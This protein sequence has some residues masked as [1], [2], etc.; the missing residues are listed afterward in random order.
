MSLS[1]TMLVLLS[2][3]SRVTSFTAFPHNSINSNA[4]AI[5]SAKTRSSPRSSYGKCARFY[6]ALNGHSESQNIVLDDNTVHTNINDSSNTNTS[7]NIKPIHVPWLIVGGGI[8]GVH[9]AA[10]LLGS[11]GKGA[12]INPDDLCIIDGNQHLL[13]MWKSRT[14][15]TGM[16]YLRSSAGYHLDIEENSLRRMRHLTVGEQNGEQEVSNTSSVEVKTRKGRKRRKMNKHK[17]NKTKMGTKAS[18]EQIFSNDYERPRLDIFNQHCD[19]VIE[20]YELDRLHRQG[21]V[22]AID[23]CGS[24]DH[25]RLEVTMASSDNGT[26]TGTGTSSEENANKVVYTAEHIVLALGNDDPSYA[27]WVNKEDIESGLVRHLLDD[28]HFT[29]SSSSGF[30]FT[31]SKSS[32]DDNHSTIKTKT[33]TVIVGG[34]ISAVHK[35]LELANA[36][37]ST[38]NTSSPSQEIHLISRHPL[39]EQQFDTHQDWMMDKAAAKRSLDGGGF[40]VPKRQRQFSQSS[41]FKERRQIIANQRVPGTVTPAVNRGEHGLRYAIENGHIQWH[42]AEILE[43][44]I[45]L[46]EEHQKTC[47]HEDS[48]DCNTCMELSLSNGE[49]IEVDEILLATGFGKKPPGG[50][51]IEED[52]IRNAGLKVS[53]FCGY[54]I[55]DENLCWHPRIFVAGALAELELGPSARNIAGARLAA[56]RILEA[57][58]TQ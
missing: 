17:A 35:A 10:R 13:Q 40:G 28:V 31:D 49:K 12:G 20:K 24:D 57:A 46:L 47:P 1:W 42:Q 45:L 36:S 44:K 43:K 30:G 26:G 15:N 32:R 23:P 5:A 14:A 29:S 50:K 34:G 9:I 54:P 52:L 39:R 25:V 37:K 33:K 56:E 21:F 41:C 11:E 3:C 4:N 27:E 48:R 6:G 51:I 16:K 53:E 58:S 8:H 19:A 2:T 55:V 7:S 38:G 22:T 18:Q